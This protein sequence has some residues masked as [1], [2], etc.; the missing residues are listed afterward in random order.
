[1]SA[2]LLTD[3]RD[4]Y[5]HLSPYYRAFWGE[6]IHHGYWEGDETPSTAQVKLTRR[7]AER[8]G[9]SHDAR[10]LD[11]GCGLGGSA[12]L[13]ARDLGCSVTGITISPAQVQLAAKGAPTAGL[14][15]RVEFLVRNANQL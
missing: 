3:I 6:H 4:H 11:V 15:D 2:Q 5:D 13:L 10:V 9:I 14:A 7:L 1:M 8:A 12:L